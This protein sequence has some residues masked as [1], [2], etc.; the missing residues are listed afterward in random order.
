ASAPAAP[1]ASSTAGKRASADKLHLDTIPPYPSR[2]RGLI[3]ERS[4]SPPGSGERDSLEHLADQSNEDHLRG[5]ERL[6][7]QERRDARLRQR[8]IGPDPAVNEC[9]EGA[10][11]DVHGTQKR[12]N[13]AQ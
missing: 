10:V 2:A 6:S 9:L 12:R 4:H 11:D 1:G 3:D 5:H 8:E 7:Q 13:Q